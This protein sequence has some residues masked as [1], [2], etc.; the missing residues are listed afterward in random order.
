[1]EPPVAKPFV[2]VQSYLVSEHAALD[3]HEYVRGRVIV[4][5]PDSHEHDHILGN[6]LFNLHG[7]LEGSPCAVK[8]SNMRLCMEP[9]AVYAFADLSV[10]CGPPHFD[11]VDEPR[12]TLLNPRVVLE[13]ASELTAA[14]DYGKRFHRYM[15]LA[16]M[17][18]YVVVDESEAAARSYLRQPNGS[19]SVTFFDDMQA[20]LRLR[21]IGVELPLAE[22]Y[23]GVT[24]RPEEGDPRMDTKKH[25]SEEVG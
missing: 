24:F 12:T 10:V 2:S 6:L 11:P 22:V 19:W 7:A 8:S 21:C 9:A 16:S 15:S 25:E 20:T 3:R 18:E 23:A 14:D 17:E 5:P 4:K 13:I 1:M